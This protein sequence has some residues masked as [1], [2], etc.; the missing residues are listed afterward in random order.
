MIETDL[1]RL[2]H[3]LRTPIN[4]LIGYSQ[5][6][7]EE[8]QQS[9]DGQEWSQS[10]ERV[11]ALGKQ[12]LGQ[13]DILLPRSGS[14]DTE[15]R[16]TELR[17]VFRQPLQ[18]ILA[19]LVSIDLPDPENQSAD[20]ER[21][22][23]AAS[24][25]LRFAD[26]GSLD[27]SPASPQEA[28]QPTP[29]GTD[30]LLIVDDDRSNRDLLARILSK[31][32]YRV[33]LAAGGNEAV[34]LAKTNKY[35]LMLLDILMPG[36]N[37]YQVLEQLKVLRPEMPVIVISAVE[38]MR[39]VVRCIEMGAEDY[40]L[41]PI[42]PALLRARIASTLDRKKFR[43]RLVAQQRLAS[44]GELTAGVAHEIKNPLNFV[45]NFS[46][47]AQE[48]VLDLKH[49]LKSDPEAVSALLEDLQQL[50]LKVKE[51]GMRADAIVKSMLLHYRNESSPEE[52]VDFNQLVAQYLKLADFS[53]D[54]EQAAGPVQVQARY[55]PD[56]GTILCR[57]ADIGRVIINLVTNA[58]HA[59]REKQHRLQLHN[60]QISVST[61]N[62]GTAVEL[63]VQDN[64]VGVPD[65]IR[66]KI[67]HPFF[68]TKAAG[69]GAGL[70]LSITH[71]IIVRSHHGELILNSKEGVGA[72]FI[73]RIP[74]K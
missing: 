10:I 63:I 46:E 13:L 52:A 29:A 62:A 51:H 31:L 61:R 70:G 36:L 71:D 37:G 54:K 72:E 42:E 50:L 43:E 1:T 67:F 16:L 27:E 69:A 33:S 60:P 45:I 9:T 11:G 40:F 73:A 22:R 34:A 47:L 55:D 18:E 15:G 6:L 14:T 53:F 21:L 48:N 25:L 39:S 57:P 3:D 24:R 7:I 23:R 26:E 41:K 44:L 17:E 66:N 58:Y 20:V 38:D 2:R 5:L 19:T 56:V 35:D 30:H 65:E 64:G 12:L 4:H 59:V 8:A 68:T 28:R 49:A 32:N 74:R